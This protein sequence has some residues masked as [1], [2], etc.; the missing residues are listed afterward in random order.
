MT[1][2]TYF[3][4][5]FT[6]SLGLLGFV[7]PATSHAA[8][9][10]Q[11]ERV[12]RKVY[13]DIAGAV[14]DYRQAPAFNF[15]PAG[16]FMSDNAFYNP[17]NTTVNLGEDIYDICI[18]FGADSLDALALVL[19]HELAHFYKDHE[20]GLAFGTAHF[21]S[22]IGEEIY[23]LSLSP[24]RKREMEAEADYFGAFF[25][26]VAGYDA[27]DIGPVFYDSLY[28]VLDIPDDTEGYPSRADRVGIA[29]GV[30]Q[31]LKDLARIF[32]A[33]N[34][35]MAVEEYESAGRCFAYVQRKFPSREVMNNAGV[36]YA[37]AAL[38]QYREG[39]L[40]FIYP[41]G[42]D[43]ETH[44]P[45]Y[46][47]K[48]GKEDP[49][50][51][52]KKLLESARELFLGAIRVDESYAQ[53]H[54]NLALVEELRGE[55][56][57]ARAFAEKGLKLALEAGETFLAGNARIAT[58]I[59]LAKSGDV[60]GAEEVL[61]HA[62]EGSPVLAE[63]NLARLKGE[64]KEEMREEGELASPLEESI[65]EEEL[66]PRMAEILL[67]EARRLEVMR[68]YEGQ[69][70]LEVRVAEGSTWM[71][72]SVKRYSFP[73]SRLNF[74]A[75]PLS[76]ELPSA[77]GIRI[78]DSEARVR[79]LYGAPGQI[80]IMGKQIYFLYPQTG[81]LFIFNSDRSVTRWVIFSK[82]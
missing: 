45:K 62:K 52:R 38:N 3:R 80:S 54:V 13:A 46:G 41:L 53:A 79:E 27:L 39:E 56:L 2:C 33:A 26:Y 49:E 22:G 40:K 67:F 77:R 78:G 32:D 72:I 19:G 5:V 15:I 81:I 17:E 60:E 21:N 69:G 1:L 7:L 73:M 64:E 25:S 58:G 70:D 16:E 31:E 4:R 10:L 82:H 29:E 68:E 11:K 50:E 23:D 24:E 63:W 76:Y 74:L 12:A 9:S 66:E 57:M 47:A 14:Q 28:A 36:C 51:K 18:H 44:L 30:R 20:W 59:A 8:N 6:L 55:G 61:K 71:G 35:L 48:S 37:R 75:T 65:G 43:T 34:F 42:L